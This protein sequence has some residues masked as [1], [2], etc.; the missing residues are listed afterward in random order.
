MIAV[1]S[2]PAPGTAAYRSLVMRT[3]VPDE[4]RIQ[5]QALLLDVRRRGDAAL[6]DL[7][8][9]FD[10]VRLAHT[11]VSRQ[12]M[13]A[14]LDNLDPGLRS[15]LDAAAAN[16]EAVHRAQRFHEEPVDVVRGARV[17]REWRPLN[18]VGIY[19]PGG[20]TV[21]PSS[22]LMLAI[23]ARLAGCQEIV[24]C[25][26]P[27]RDGQVA[28]VILAAAGLAGVTEVHAVGGA[29]AVAAMA[30]GTESVPRVDRIVGPG[31][32]YVAEAKIQVS[33]AVAID[34][35]AG[36]SELLVLCDQTA[37]PAGVAREL[38]A[39]AEHDPRAAVV[40]VT[41]PITTGPLPVPPSVAGGLGHSRKA[42]GLPSAPTI[43]NR[44]FRRSWISVVPSG[45][46]MRL[47]GK[48]YSAQA[49]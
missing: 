12:T 34:S 33:S 40:A 46:G 5:T 27:Q 4:V 29:Q 45:S 28:A 3:P 31:N 26:P 41:T 39:Q 10:G 17:W 23:P 43:R 48:A 30:Y 44:R 9:R 32:A 49:T 24:L 36:P 8:Q 13:R 21:Y 2:L 35:P 25:S 42:P 11:N 15:A 16:I 20:K 37:D 22:V 18:R 38:L 1:D 19:V 7:T 47:I 6:L 14:A